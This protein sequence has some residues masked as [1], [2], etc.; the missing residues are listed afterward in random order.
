MTVDATAQ[1][2]G[3]SEP[4]CLPRRI[5]KSDRERAVAISSAARA[6]A[7]PI[8]VEVLDLLR[9]AD[10]EVCQCELQ[11]LFDV[12]QPTLSHHLRKLIEADLV[13]VDRRG[14]WAYYALSDNALEVFRSW[15]S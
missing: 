5:E 13:S 1:R 6:L 8:R 10:G 9:Q 4:C 14:K 15:L 3:R 2:A 12:S 7:D 11:P